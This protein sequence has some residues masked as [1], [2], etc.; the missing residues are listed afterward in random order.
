MISFHKFPSS[1]TASPVWLRKIART[2][3]SR[4]CSLHFK[5]SDFVTESEDGNKYR[6]RR[7][8]LKRRL[9]KDS[10]SIFP[11][12]PAHL[13]ETLQRVEIQVQPRIDLENSRR[14][15]LNETFEAVDYIS[16]CD[17]QDENFTEDCKT[18][19]AFVIIRIRAV[20]GDA[21]LIIDVGR[22]V[23]P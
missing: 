12:F 6:E 23:L 19:T 5:D 20:S 1:A 7:R 18:P 2:S 9:K 3:H 17:E 8:L 10:T 21:Y 16:C 4:V 14:I 22:T 13:R 15:E 11:D